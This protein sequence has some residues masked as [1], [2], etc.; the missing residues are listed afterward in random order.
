MKIS[1][2]TIKVY[3]TRYDRLGYSN[4][5]PG[6]WKFIDLTD[7]GT[8]YTSSIGP[9]YHS[10]M[11]LLSDLDRFAKEF[12]GFTSSPAVAPAL[13]TSSTAGTLSTGGK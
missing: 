2:T 5:F 9:N 13:G 4:M 12:F 3:E 11:E 6:R 8:P 10:R 7:N 1:T